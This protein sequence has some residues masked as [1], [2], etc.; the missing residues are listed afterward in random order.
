M[1]QKLAEKQGRIHSTS[2]SPSLFLPAKKEVTDG[3]TDQRTD[4]PTN[5]RTYTLI[6]PLLTTKNEWKR[7]AREIE[8]G[9][10]ERD[11]EEVK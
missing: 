11:D 1:R 4:Q 7:R 10:K 9:E 2:R 6:Q 8:K 3:P 5:G